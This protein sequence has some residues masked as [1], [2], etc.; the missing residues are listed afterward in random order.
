MATQEAART[1][2]P[3]EILGQ[4]WTF[5]NGKVVKLVEYHDMD[6]IAEF[7]SAAAAAMA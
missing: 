3:R 6:R 5:R 4:F 7:A 2:K 1:Y